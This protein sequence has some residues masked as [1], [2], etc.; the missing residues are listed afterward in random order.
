M[1]IKN[2]E[3]Y[4]EIVQQMHLLDSYTEKL[5]NNDLVSTQELSDQLAQTIRRINELK[6]VEYAAGISCAYAN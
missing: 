2:Y 6:S 1:N 3:L 4:R 5:E